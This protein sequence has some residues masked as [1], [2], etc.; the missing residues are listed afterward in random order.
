MDLTDI[1]IAIIA[2]DFFEESEL[3]EPKKSFIKAFMELIQDSTDEE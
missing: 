3:A 1:K 2:T